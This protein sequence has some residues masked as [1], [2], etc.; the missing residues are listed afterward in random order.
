MAN[1]HV[2]RQGECLSSIAADY[3]FVD[4]RT[5]YEHPDNADFRA[6][7]PNPNLI[8]PGD[9]IVIPDRREKEE[10]G[11][12][13][14]RHRFVRRGA[15]HRLKVR[16]QDLEGEPI[17]GAPYRLL[18]DGKRYEGNTAGD[19]MVEQ[20]IS[21]Q[22]RYGELTVWPTAAPSDTDPG[23]A[24]L[25]WT[26]ALGHLDPVEELTGVQAR[27]NNLGFESGPVDGIMGPI[28]RSAVRRFQEKHALLVD[29]IP[30]PQTQGKLVEV[31]G[32]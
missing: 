23:P 19:G 30:G 5:V 8:Y 14:Q 1:V 7:R 6:L 10:S 27:L 28:T 16:V 11:D 22:A 13:E 9:R 4:W 31:Y 24:C 3:G 32:C 2:V 20:V 29:G 12:T 25:T 18:V 15:R 17:A 26:L 21:P